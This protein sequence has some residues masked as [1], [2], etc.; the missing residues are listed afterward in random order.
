M[1]NATQLALRRELA[2][3][4]P[5]QT[6]RI[7]LAKLRVHP[8]HIRRDMGDLAE[9]AESLANEG[10]HQI[11]KVERRGDYFQILDGHRRFG[12]ATIAGLRSLNAEIG[13]VCT[14]AEALSMMLTTG[15]HT[16]P[17]SA[18]ERAHAV[19]ILVDDENLKFAEVAARC[20]VSEATIRRWYQADDEPDAT[21]AVV[22][23]PRPRRARH[24]RQRGKPTTVGVTRLNGL[25]DRWTVRCEQ[26]LSAEHAQA[27]LAEIRALAAGQLD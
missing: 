18:A 21:S 22:V 7:P 26:G 24:D 19:R 3:H 23:V 1:S 6:R 13:P 25:A 8:R 27:L 10:Q 16:K 14:D 9:L 4:R 12:A 15:V 11:I 2:D 20:G 17:L 5:M